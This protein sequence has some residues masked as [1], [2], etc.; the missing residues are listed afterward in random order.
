MRL[1]IDPGTGSMLFSLLAGLFGAGAWAARGLYMKWRVRARGGGTPGED[2][3]L[4]IYS[5]D[6]RYWNVF[7]P[8]CD[9]LERR[10]IPTRYL[11]SSPDDPGLARPYAH[12]RAAYIGRDEEAFATLNGLKARV[13]LAT[14]PGLDVY[15]WKRSKD[16]PY[17][18]HVPHAPGDITRYR[19]YGIDWFDAILL[20]GEYQIH[21]VRELERIRGLPPKELRLVGIGYLD[22][23]RA[24]LEREGR[25][26]SDGTLTVMM[27]P[28]WGKSGILSRYGERA[29]RALLDTGS[30][31]IIRPHPQS[32]QSE[33]DLL[34]RLEAAFPASEKLEWNRDSDNFD[35]LRRTDV[36]ISDFSGIIFD[37]ALVFD[38]PVIYADTSFDPGPYD[39]WSLDEELWTFRTLPKIGRPLREE[40]LEGEKLKQALAEAAV[41]PESRAA[42][43]QARLETWMYPGEAA[44]R[45]VDFLEEKLGESGTMKAGETRM[46]IHPRFP[47]HGIGVEEE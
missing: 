26:A 4:V 2:T 15:Q 43:R 40:D 7:G 31:V 14:T 24:R 1:Y 37:A 35:A 6:R 28:S 10:G 30:R 20:S 34:A 9:E 25:A 3:P 13:L 12:I 39:A 16:I 33:A 11:T 42:R 41:D 45:T 46:E 38:L 5:D 18:V 22:A 36:L 17:Y 44:V 8:I 32:W 23:M 47:G 29:I 19:M 27:A 21:Q